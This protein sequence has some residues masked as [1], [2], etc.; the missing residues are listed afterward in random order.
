VDAVGRLGHGTL[1]DRGQCEETRTER[2]EMQQRL[3][4]ESTQ[5]CSPAPHM[6]SIADDRA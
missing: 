4:K 5:D 2:E 6:R 1:Q 3:A